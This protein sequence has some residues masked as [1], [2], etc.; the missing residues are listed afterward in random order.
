MFGVM[1]LGI[2]GTELMLELG[3]GVG[4]VVQEASSVAGQMF[5]GRQMS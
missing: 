5:C 2:L 1:V 4:A 3:S